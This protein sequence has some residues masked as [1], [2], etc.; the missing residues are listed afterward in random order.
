[1]R[2]S[3]FSPFLFLSL[4]S[5]SLFSGEGEKAPPQKKQKAH[6]AGARKQQ[7][8][9]KGAE[10]EKKRSSRTKNKWASSKT[11]P[12]VNKE[13]DV[14]IEEVS[15]QATREG[16]PYYKAVSRTEPSVPSDRLDRLEEKVDALQERVG[17]E[18]DSLD[19]PHA[20]F[21]APRGHVYLT[22]EW[23]FWKTRQEGMEYALS[24][25]I[26]F[27][28]TSGFR[29]G[30]GVHLPQD[31]WDIYANYTQ[32]HPS[33]SDHVHHPV[34]PL[35]LYGASGLVNEAHGH[36]G[37]EFQSADVEIGR[38]FYLSRSLSFRPHI[39]LKGAWID[40]DAHFHYRGGFVPNGEEFKTEMKNDFK[41]AGPRIG[42]QSNWHLGVGLSFF[43]DVACALVIGQ[44]H[45][46]QEQEQLAGF[47]PVHLSTNSYLVSPNLQLVTGIAWDRN[48]YRDHCHFGIS[49]GF[50]AQIYWDQN[51]VE[52]FTTQ[53]QPI[54][55]RE[56]GDLAFYGLTLRARI[57]F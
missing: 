28:Y 35:F 2:S 27:D 19:F 48:F 23:L 40:Q 32:L 9:P 30:L 14:E 56:K 16:I 7:A 22:G 55:V 33:H 20:G 31:G 53:G 45:N 54:Y 13:E 37:I 15:F 5:L 42:M 12:K 3:L 43:G 44:I 38:A 17:V 6:Y 41:G 57:D 25:Q 50:E 29:V 39:G 52:Q 21:Q 47:E 24:K 46:H 18:G 49:A 36:W 1:M 34:F 4:T 10:G 26:H 51:Q 11:Y 8:R